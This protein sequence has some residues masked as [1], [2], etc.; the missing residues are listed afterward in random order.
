LDRRSFGHFFYP[1]NSPTTPT[2]NATT[3]PTNIRIALSVGEPVK[4]REMSEL[5]DV[6]AI[7]TE[8]E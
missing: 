7:D 4:K 8:D 2:T 1:C 5:N 6:D 3:P